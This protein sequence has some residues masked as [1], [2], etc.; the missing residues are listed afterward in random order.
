MEFKLILKKLN[1]S[2]TEEEE[3]IFDAWVSESELHRDYFERVKERHLKSPES[4]S[5]DTGWAKLSLR[6]KK[7]Q[8]KH[9]YSK[10][11]AA[12]AILL[13]VSLPFWLKETPQRVP[14]QQMVEKKIEAGTDKATLTLEDGTEVTLEKG[15]SFSRNNVHS[16]GEQL[17]YTNGADIPNTN[18]RYNTLTIPRGGQFYVV[19]AD[20]TKVWLNSDSKLRYPVNFLDDQPRTVELVY[21]EAYFEVS[22]SRLHNGT[23]FMVNTQ[24]QQVDV[25][26]TAFNI[27]AYKEDSVVSTAL[28]HGRIA[29][30]Q[31]GD[32]K[33]LTPGHQSVF[34]P[35]SGTVEISKVDVSSI[36]AWKDGLFNF[37]DMPLSEILVTISRWYDTEIQIRNQEKAAIEFNGMFNRNQ[38]LEK[39]LSIIENTNEVK[40]TTVGNT[41]IV[42]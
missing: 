18:L 6:L 28:V 30:N 20:S 32:S 15:G 27:K 17:V 13:L 38:E 22:P 19:L 23:H 2:L 33:E 14:V 25:L 12:A 3:K 36:V 42:D 31:R 37:K 9:S 26:G 21:G 39:I 24:G 40:F 16:N 1:N 35:L 10:Y 8:K 7:K 41:I 34:D 29:I 5:V 11:A 4:V